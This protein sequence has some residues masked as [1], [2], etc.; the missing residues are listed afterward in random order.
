MSGLPPP[1]G[2]ARD[3]ATTASEASA[4][5]GGPGRRS[6]PPASPAGEHVWL[7][8]VRWWDAGFAST[9]AFIAGWAIVDLGDAGRLGAVL[10]LYA[11]LAAWYGSTGSS[12]LAGAP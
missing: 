4:D 1:R 7:K 10:G 9:V 11:A 6:R 2:A 3:E 8:L 12:V 5:P